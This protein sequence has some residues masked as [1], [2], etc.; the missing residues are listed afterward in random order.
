[1]S[2]RTSA[3]ATGWDGSYLGVGLLRGEPGLR[4]GLVPYRARGLGLVSLVRSHA[5]ALCDQRGWLATQSDTSS[6][7][8]V[9]L[10]EE[11]STTCDPKGA[12]TTDNSA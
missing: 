3:K 8:E 5:R 12:Q 11:S 9:G 2:R 1:V 10:S 4:S 7:V 6:E